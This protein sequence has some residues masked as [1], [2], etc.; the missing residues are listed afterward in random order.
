MYGKE[1]GRFNR[2]YETLLAEKDLGGRRMHSGCTLAQPYKTFVGG[3]QYFV[4]LL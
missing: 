3:V 4:D 1:V 2:V